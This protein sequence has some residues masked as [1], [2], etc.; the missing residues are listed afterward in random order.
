MRNLLF[1]LTVYYCVI[2]VKCCVCGSIIL[3]LLKVLWSILIDDV[4]LLW[5]YCDIII[6]SNVLCV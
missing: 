4:T 3:L 6:D 2:I 5:P 1:L